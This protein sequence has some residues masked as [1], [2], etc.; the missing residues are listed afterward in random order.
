M[1]RL[2]VALGGAAL[3]SPLTGIG[4]YTTQLAAALH[5]AG[6]ELSIFN[7]YRWGSYRASDGSADI[8]RL[9]AQAD[10]RVASR[11][12]ALIRRLPYVRPAVR[13]LQQLRFSLGLPPNVQLYHEPNFIPYQT[14]LPTVITVHDLSWIRHPEAHP[15]DRVR[16]M[17]KAFPAA[18][19]QA[20]Q[21]LVDSVFVADE[22]RALFPAA[23]A[24]VRPV[25]LGVSPRFRPF[26]HAIMRP[27]LKQAGLEPGQYLLALGTLEPRKNLM[28]AIEAFVRLPK[29]VR[30]RSPLV[31]IGARGWHEQALLDRI[32]PLEVSGEVRRLGY[33]ADDA[34]PAFVSGAA[35][36][37]YPS[38]YEGFGLPPLEAMACGVPV[39]ASRAASIPEVT[40]DAAILCEPR[41]VDAFTHAM[42]QVLEAPDMAAAMAAKGLQQAAG[43]TWQRC[44]QQTIAAYGDALNT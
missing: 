17:E 5:Q 36:L 44:A 13:V 19:E 39:I 24:R 14:D 6:I 20:R 1:T 10:L 21:I 42:R 25:L 27:V 37:V 41:D 15:I 38:L 3:L 33:I 8:G 28:T 43:F 7:S 18:L 29:S 26:D 30:Q 31:L 11:A 12:R 32:G 2:R 35:A 9:A 22:V 34:L 4:Q 23:S 16:F 40:G